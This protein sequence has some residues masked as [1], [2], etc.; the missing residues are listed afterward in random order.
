MTLYDPRKIA[1]CFNNWFCTVFT[2]NS[3][4]FNDFSCSDI[5]ALSFTAADVQRA[6]GK[7]SNGIGHDGISGYVLREASASL[8]FHVYKLFCS[9]ADRAVYPPEWKIAHITPVY[10][11]GDER[12]VTS[13]RPISILPK[14]SL[15]FERII[16]DNLY[17]HIRNKICTSQFGFVKKRS[18]ILQL[19]SFL[20]NVYNCI[21]NNNNLY[22]AYLDF[23]KAFD[24]VSH[25][26]LLS[27][28]RKFG[29]GGNLLKL[30]AS[31]LA[32][33][34]QCVK[35]DGIFS[36][37]RGIQSGVPQGSILGPLLFLIFINDMPEC[38]VHSFMF[39]YADDSK[40]CNMSLT[41]LQ[42]DINRCVNWASENLMSFNINKT[43][44]L[45]FGKSCSHDSISMQSTP[46]YKSSHVKD[47]GLTVD[48]NLKWSLPYP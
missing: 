31:Y 17:N 41:D 19:I 15:A 37:L 18:T 34:R 8:S 11:S 35:I 13:Y 48:C 45:I 32:D 39:L 2:S 22:C 23:S 10:K 21:D 28:A 29:I 5:N 3:T 43:S 25:T 38:C 16:F 33:R 40:L 30:L 46:V 24:K 14:M 36:S 9:I 20:D 26:A 1:D 47:L 7:S 42:N 6:L 27:K 4:T 12:L 44:F